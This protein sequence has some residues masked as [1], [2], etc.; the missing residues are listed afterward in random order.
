M[1]A[2]VDL[3]LPLSPTSATVSPERSANDTS[4]SAP[5]FARSQKESFTAPVGEDQGPMTVT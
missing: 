5:H 1:R 2:V 3:P 4:S